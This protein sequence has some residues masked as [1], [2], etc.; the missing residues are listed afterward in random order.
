MIEKKKI[1]VVS[2]LPASGKTSLI[3]HLQ[4]SGLNGVEFVKEFLEPM[5]L[6]FRN[7]QVLDFEQK[8]MAQEW[9][10]EQNNMKFSIALSNSKS[11][12]TTIMD[13]G[14]LDVLAYSYVMD[15]KIYNSILRKVP[16]SFLDIAHTI[17]LDPEL[18]T[19][20]DRTT[21]RS[22]KDA[23]NE[24]QWLAFLENL[25]TAFSTIILG[26]KFSCDRF[27]SRLDSSKL[28]LSIINKY[29]LAK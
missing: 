15:M 12:I 28:A 14:Y 10:L 23:V 25:E 26:S 3:S 6:Q 7:P 22:G 19:L 5:P 29:F 21:K 9:V 16:S 11:G 4:A 18:N 20:L 24:I 27:D 17:Y 1:F 13:R 8:L 2:G